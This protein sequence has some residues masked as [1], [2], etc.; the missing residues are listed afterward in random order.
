M[1]NQKKQGTAQIGL[2]SRISPEAK[3]MFEDIIYALDVKSQEAIETVIQYYYEKEKVKPRP[4]RARLGAAK[5]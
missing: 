5:R 3:K 2:F 1:A 4:S